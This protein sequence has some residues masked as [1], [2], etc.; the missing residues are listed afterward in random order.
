MKRAVPAVPHDYLPFV[1]VY[2]GTPGMVLL[3]HPGSRRSIL[4]LEDRER[5]QDIC[6][7]PARSE[8]Y[9]LEEL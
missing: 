6:T 8:T 5:V 9:N 7:E 3:T 1:C 2:L 4:F